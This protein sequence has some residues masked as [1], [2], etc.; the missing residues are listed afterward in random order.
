MYWKICRT[1]LPAVQRK[2]A[3]GTAS[4]SGEVHRRAEIKRLRA[5]FGVWLVLVGAVAA[6]VSLSGCASPYGASEDEYEYNAATGYP[7]VGYDS[8]HL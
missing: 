7:A 6:A 1:S 8:W 2:I 3:G 4:L 5:G